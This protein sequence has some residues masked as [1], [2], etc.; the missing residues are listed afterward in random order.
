MNVIDAEVTPGYERLIRQLLVLLTCA[1]VSVLALPGV[2]MAAASAKTVS[3][4]GVS[5]AVPAGWPVIRVD[6]HSTICV[7]F[8]RHAVYLGTPG[9]QERCPQNLVGRTE[10][11]LIQPEPGAAGGLAADSRTGALTPTSTVLAAPGAGS[12]I[13]LVT[14]AH[15]VLIT[16]TWNHDPQLIRT[17]LHLD[18]LADA[19]RATNGHRP[20]A[21][22]STL[23]PRPSA[24]EL[25]ARRPHAAGIAPSPATPG[26]VFTGLGFDAC[27]APSS[28]SLTAWQTD[29]PFQALGVYIGGTNMACSQSNLT[30]AWVS[31]ESAAGWHMIPTYVGLQAPGNSCG[32]AAITPSD[33]ASEGAAAAQDAV[34][35]AQA[36]GIGTGNPIYYDMESYTRSASVTS[37]VLSFLNAWTTQ[38][39]SSGYLS[40]VYSSGASGITDLVDAAGTS[41]FTEPDELWVAHWNGEATAT[42]SYVP[43]AD[44]AD[45][46]LIHQYEGESSASGTGYVG[47]LTYGGVTIGVD[48][49]YLD[50]ATAAAGSTASAPI[51]AIATAPTLTV[52]PESN[53]LI[54]LSPQWSGQAAVAS[55][56]I[57]GGPSATSLT[58]IETIPASQALPLVVADD[59]AYFSVTALNSAG[60]VIG[61]SQPTPT[62]A[63]VA[64]YTNSTFAP[65]NAGALA[66]GTISVPV[67][68]LNTDPCAV[69]AAIY[70]GKKRLAHSAVQTLSAQGGTIRLPVT[71]GVL[72]ALSTGVSR[73]VSVT[74]ATGTGIRSTRTLELVPYS[75]SGPAPTRKTGP[76]TTL[77]ILAKTLFVSDGWVGGV[78]VQCTAPTPC[79]ASTRVTTHGGRVVV[80]VPRTQTLGSGQIGYLT[81]T[82]TQAG[83][84]LLRASTGNQLGARVTVIP[85]AV[86]GSVA[87]IAS[88]SGQTTALVSLDSY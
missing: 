10:A 34:Y 44:W 9:V 21:A 54:E 26:E 70:R 61:S 28:A 23:S 41:G 72:R 39:H 38:L 67:G 33:A 29:S 35:Q 31:A 55:W 77:R 49:D 15:R 17:A 8:D 5:V 64:I 7:R 48:E 73:K 85:S 6:Q 56:A 25:S 86:G 69:Q 13:K 82:M 76:S 4:R 57:S 22:T 36:L 18:S 83:H 30:A 24:T 60:A 43:A 66:H 37:T 16:A 58:P 45:H 78:L 12:M 32:C 63:S 27:S 87:S 75:T 84:R 11:I 71:T 81:F 62:P 3:Y 79:T 74:V 68:C 80:A 40:G 42:D 52:Q 46:Q 19:A 14:K 65:T 53:G 50:A 51:P 59:D 88:A 1:A 2:S 47:P 20:A